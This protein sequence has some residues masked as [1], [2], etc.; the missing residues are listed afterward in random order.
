MLS[1]ASRLARTYQRKNPFHVNNPIVAPCCLL[2]R[3]QLTHCQPSTLFNH[4]PSSLKNRRQNGS[5]ASTVLKRPGYEKWRTMKVASQSDVTR[6]ISDII[7][8][9]IHDA[10]HQP[11]LI[12]MWTKSLTNMIQYTLLRTPLAISSHFLPQ[13]PRNIGFPFSA[14]RFTENL[15]VLK[16][17]VERVRQHVIPLPWD[18][19]M[20]GYDRK[21]PSVQQ[22]LVPFKEFVTL[23]RVLLEM[24]LHMWHES[25]VKDK[26]NDSSVYTLSKVWLQ[27]QTYPDYYRRPY[28]F[29]TDGWLS[30][31][32]AQA[33]DGLS[34]LLFDGRQDAMQRMAVCEIYT[35]LRGKVRPKIVELGAGT[36]RVATHVRHSL[37]HADL[38]LVDLSPFY[39]EQARAAIERWRSTVCLDRT[40]NVG[41]VIFVQEN[42]TKLSIAD[43]SVDAVY[44]VYLLHELPADVRRAVFTEAARILRPN[45]LFVVVDSIQ[46]MD[47]LSWGSRGKSF[48]RFGE[49]WFE[50][51]FDDRLESLGLE[52]NLFKPLAVD[53][54]SVT[55]MV[56]F[57]RVT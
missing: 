6:L 55:K 26:S 31:Q 51:Y 40:V 41:E 48:S 46:S 7:Q 17:D 1:R 43:N 30:S 27:G 14:S 5:S 37:P 29:Q 54:C 4:V 47:R 9:I 28:H 50:S 33:Y 34:Q 20:P 42:A 12:P 15:H 11:Q 22:A 32:S 2:F 57:L 44:S 3:R 52:N 56:S 24:G 45:G 16:D 18:L 38:T 10:R 19:T 49:P 8:D 13:L 39:L 53:M 25:S 35:N 36:G 23:T 21:F